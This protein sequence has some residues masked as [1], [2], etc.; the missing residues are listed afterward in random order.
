[1][2]TVVVAGDTDTRFARP[3]FAS[4]MH[5][6]KKLQIPNSKLQTWS[7][8]LGDGVRQVGLG[9]TGICVSEKEFF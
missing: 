4:W 1:M 3:V 5:L 6:S 2:D 9:P 7:S 8:V